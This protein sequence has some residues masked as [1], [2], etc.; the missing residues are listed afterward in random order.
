MRKLLLILVSALLLLPHSAAAS[1]SSDSISSPYKFKTTDIIAP[2][3]LIAVGV[4]GLEWK[5]LKKVNHKVTDALWGDG[6]KK[7]KIDNF[8]QILPIAAP[9]VLNLC[10]VKGLHGYADLAIIT[11][12][13]GLML[14][15]V[16]YPL[17][18]FVNSPRPG[19]ETGFNSFPSG[20]SAWAFM[21]AEILRREYWKVSPWIGVSGYLVAAGTAFMRLYNGA[22]WLTDVMAGAGLGILCAEAAYW[23]YPAVVKHLFPSR[24]RSN[25]FLSPTASSR[26]V[27]MAFS[28]TF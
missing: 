14:A 24:Y 23:L 2:A 27:G 25:I 12:T 10:G 28:M 22:H 15:S 18:D 3:A 16:V 26:S 11:A 5:G 4:A 7:I 19:G 13:A 1:E 21:G 17:K 6:H 8:T 9:Y 20:H